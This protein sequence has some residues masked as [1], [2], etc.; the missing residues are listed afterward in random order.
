MQGVGETQEH[1]RLPHTCGAA[2]WWGVC[3]RAQGRRGALKR[4]W[5]RSPRKPRL[6]GSQEPPP[7][8]ANPFPRP[9]LL[10]AELRVGP[11]SFPPPHPRHPHPHPPP[12]PRV[13]SHCPIM[14]AILQA[15]AEMSAAPR[16]LPSSDWMKVMSQPGVSCRTVAWK[17]SL[18]L[19]EEKKRTGS[20]PGGCR[21]K[22]KGVVAGGRLP[23]MLTWDGA[24]RRS[25]Q[26]PQ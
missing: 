11:P 15:T 16:P 20:R 26:P 7:P 10:L 12:P 19:P 17:R 14:Q 3:L 6:L 22:R 21:R 9:S 2:P 1:P 8:A 5:R 13:L 25:R 4:P 18:K 24:C 23:G